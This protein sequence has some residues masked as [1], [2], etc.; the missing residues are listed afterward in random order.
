MK[1][2]NL[3]LALACLLVFV[4]LGYLFFKKWAVQKPFGI[5]LFVADGLSTNTLTAARL[6]DRGPDH[7]LTVESLPHVVLLTNQSNDFAVP[8]AAAAATA[9]A[10]GEKG[11]NRSIALDPQGKKL[12]SIIAKAREAGRATGIITTGKLTDP[13][14]A[15]F[16]AH[17][18]D[19][20]DSQAIALQFLTDAKVDIAMGGGLADFT[21]VSKGGQRKDG[22]DLW[23]ELRAKGI[24]MVRAKAELENRPS[25][26]TG[27]MVGIFADGNLPY[28]SEVQ[29]G[30]QQPSLSDM[31]RRSIEFLQT[32]SGGY[33]LVVDA[34][35][36]SRASEQNNSERVLTE[37]VDFDRAIAT[38]LEYAGEKALIIAVGKH[39]VG[40]LAL[41]GYPLR[42]DHG[43]AMLGTN[44]GGVPAV[45]WSTGPNGFRN[46]AAPTPG[47][48]V[49][50][51]SE[52]KPAVTGSFAAI[53]TTVLPAKGPLPVVSATGA[54]PSQAPPEPPKNTK[55]EPAAF[56]ASEAINTARDMIGVGTGPGS[57]QLHG[58]LDN[59]DIFKI[60][61]QSL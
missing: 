32:N 40:G 58:F 22:R 46:S 6:Y 13:T 7:R 34:A 39:D 31:V 59:T 48:T 16:Y 52:P 14:P 41:N 42:S 38:A 19:G 43:V 55:A 10:T 57:E 44:A 35:L 3:L 11:N 37:T 36:I 54:K 4:A 33:F 20:R 18:A 8:D 45:T 12:A 24:A 15:A 56:G 50:S 60:L 17:S 23:L 30:S 25:F 26:L 27:P 51:T 1:T 47:R 28:S 49:S 5:I 2:R 9:I 53:G 61:K 29:S 21:P